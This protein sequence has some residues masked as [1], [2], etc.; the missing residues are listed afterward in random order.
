VHLL[1]LYVHGKSE[2]LEFF[3]SVRKLKNPGLTIL[4]TRDVPTR[5]NSKELAIDRVLKLKA[6]ILL[7][8]KK[9][10]GCPAFTEEDFDILGLIQPALRIFANLTAIYSMKEAHAY[11][12]L[13]DLHNAITKLEELGEDERLTEERSRSFQVAAAKLKK[14]MTRFLQNDWLCAAYALHPENRESTLER[15]LDA[16][17]QKRRKTGVVRWI[18]DRLAV[19]TTEHED[20]SGSPAPRRKTLSQNV[21]PLLKAYRI[22]FHLVETPITRG[23]LRASK[24]HGS[25]GTLM[26]DQ[27][28][29]RILM[30]GSCSI[31]SGRITFRNSGLLPV[32]HEMF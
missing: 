23:K 31:G 19:Y 28:S 6:T 9:S 30:K 21:V 27:G 2:R 18:K 11:R 24:M 25:C 32:S 14:Y 17:G 22:P 29:W 15:L 20:G 7:Y 5:W 12:V 1:G 10:K 16:Y 8:C 13:P 3:K 26:V 4:P